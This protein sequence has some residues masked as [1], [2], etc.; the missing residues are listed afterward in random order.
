MIWF[1][2]SLQVIVIMA[3]VGIIMMQKDG[4]SL[5]SASKAFGARGR[6]NFIIKLTYILGSVFLINCMILGILYKKKYNREMIF[7]QKTQ[8]VETKNQ[9]DQKDNTKEISETENTGKI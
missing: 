4:E 6:S 5:F 1:F 8:I 3:T 9:G 7:D 2:Y